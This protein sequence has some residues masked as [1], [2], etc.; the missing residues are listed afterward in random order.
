MTILAK[1]FNAKDYFDLNN[2]QL[3]TTLIF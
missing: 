1:H 3:R 2:A